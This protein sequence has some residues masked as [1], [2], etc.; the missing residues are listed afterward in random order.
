MYIKIPKLSGSSVAGQF[1]RFS[2]VGTIAFAVN[3]GLVA[4]LAPKIGPALGQMAAFPAATSVAWWL[5]RHYTFGASH[6]S[7][8]AEWSRYFSANVFGWLV[9][10]GIFFGLIAISATAHRMPVLGVAAG[11]IAG[12]AFNFTASRSMVFKTRKNPP[13]E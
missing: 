3:A 5:N 2:V 12:L 11:S 8:H 9:N 1:L 4:L 13:L 7:W 6:G 10:N